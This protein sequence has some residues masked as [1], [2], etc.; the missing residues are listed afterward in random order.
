MLPPAGGARRRGQLSRSL[1]L[2]LI[3]PLVLLL[4]WTFFLPIARLLLTSF[5]E[6]TFGFSNYVR[7]W[8]EPLYL[9]VFVRTLW[10]ATA[11]TV[12]TLLIGYPVAMLMARHGGRF[13]II[14]TMCV[15]IPLWTPVLVRSY[16]WIDPARAERPHQ[17]LAHGHGL[18][19]SRSSSSTPTAPCCWR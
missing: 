5:T 17:Q 7:L 15:L 3:A 6:P 4:G 1:S 19:A 9:Q 10:I 11:C 18:I 12:F 8:T 16:A 13:A 14:A 2:L